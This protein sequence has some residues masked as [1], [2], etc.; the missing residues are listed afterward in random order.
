MMLTSSCSSRK[1]LSRQL[2]LD[3]DRRDRKKKRERERERE[4][5][6]ERKRERERERDSL[7]SYSWMRTIFT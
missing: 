2:F 1:L 6:K 7:G 5:K 3:E 4:R